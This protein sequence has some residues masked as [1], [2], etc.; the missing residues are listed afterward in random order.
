MAVVRRAGARDRSVVFAFHMALYRTHRDTVMPRALRPLIDYRDLEGV[1]REDVDAMLADRNTTVMLAEV[2][3][4][5]I[6]YVSGHVEVD[7][8][9]I[10]RKRGIMGDWYVDES[11][12]GQGVGKELVAALEA[13]FLSSGC[14]TMESATWAF[15]TGARKAHKALGFSEVQIVYRKVLTQE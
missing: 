6:G 8:R 4:T 3:G 9:R 7:E 14:D 2:G 10:A 11:A 5:P 1:L 13:A 12:R 15:N